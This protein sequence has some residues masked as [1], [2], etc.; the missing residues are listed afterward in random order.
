MLPL[1]LPAHL[2]CISDHPGFYP[3]L[4]VLELA[5]RLADSKDL[6]GLIQSIEAILVL[7]SL[8]YGLGI[9]PF[10]CCGGCDKPL[11]YTEEWIWQD[12]FCP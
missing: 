3:A 6:K 8:N 11:L 12:P 2:R 5:K 9:I 7:L 10:R 1:D 4:A